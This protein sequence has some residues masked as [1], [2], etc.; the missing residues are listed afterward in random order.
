MRHRVLFYI[1]ALQSIIHVDTI[2]PVVH[3]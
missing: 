2:F 3:S 1:Y